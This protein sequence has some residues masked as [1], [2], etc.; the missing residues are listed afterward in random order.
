MLKELL[1]RLGIEDGQSGVFAGQWQPRPGGD[2]LVSINPSTG[3][4]LARLRTADRGD[5]D[6]V[7]E[8]AQKSFLAWR[9]IPA[10]QRGD[11]V[12][13]I[14]EALRHYKRDLGLLVTLEVGKIRS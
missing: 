8:V 6:R 5:Y 11:I 9:R 1:Q 10:P 4:P 12:R 13:R 14:G 7:L 2:E 3:Q